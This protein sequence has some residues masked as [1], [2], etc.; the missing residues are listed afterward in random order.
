MKP[1]VNAPQCRV[2][3][4][5]RTHDT[6]LRVV[7]VP[8]ELNTAAD[9]LSKVDASCVRLHPHEFAAIAQMIGAK[10]GALTIDRFADCTNAQLPRFDS[11]Q[12][13]PGAESIDAFAQNWRTEVNWCF[14]PLT[15]TGR[16]IQ[17]MRKC[18]AQGAV[19]V[20]HWPSR[21]W[22]DQLW[23]AQ[24][25]DFQTEVV[26][27]ALRIFN[28][29]EARRGRYTPW[30]SDPYNMIQNFERGKWVGQGMPNWSVSVLFLDFRTT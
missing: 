3:E 1:D 17:H 6:R 8:R 7:W 10:H 13:S 27:T 21:A 2:L 14:A 24:K 19:L 5:C 12:L 25:G 30:C 20:P 11:W 9:A 26:K 16:V 28:V 22:W 29:R 18:K 4:A 23:D 15:I